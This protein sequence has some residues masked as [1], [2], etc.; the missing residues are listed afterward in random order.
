MN[1]FSQ[2]GV[3]TYHFF[4]CFRIMCRAAFPIKMH[5]TLVNNTKITNSTKFSK[6]EAACTLY[7]V[8]VA[9]LNFSIFQTKCDA[10]SIDIINFY[11]LLLRISSLFFNFLAL[12][13]GY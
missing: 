13:N 8:P 10:E 7:D 1:S 9:Q 2:G 4:N 5:K 3:E 12:C 6:S 11:F